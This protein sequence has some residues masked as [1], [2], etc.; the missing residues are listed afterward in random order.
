MNGI[1]TITHLTLHEAKGRKVM[2]AALILGIAFLVIFGIGFHFI[3]QDLQAPARGFV[4]RRMQQSVAI[5]F[6]GM[7]GLYA[8]NFLTVMMAVLMPVDTLSGEIRSGAIQTLV[9]KPISREQVV[10]GKWLGFWL[11]LAG[12]LLLMAGGVLLIVRWISG[13][14][15]N[16]AGAGIA[17]MLLESTVLLTLS[18][19]GGTR[20]STLANGVMV[21]GLYGFAFI[22]GWLEQIGTLLG[23]DTAQ[24]IGVI[25]SLVVPT[26]SLW[27]LAAYNM[28]SPLIRDLAITPFSVSSVP[29]SAMIVW[30]IAYIAVMLILALRQFRTRDL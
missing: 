24:N 30:A 13:Q 5:S 18:I 22:G 14:M 20:L 27:Q 21:F 17:L 15:T 7:A 28:Q 2:Q 26:E 8:V 1:L 4:P 6:I 16:N 19:L 12:Y 29:S 11:L 3:Y 10:L 23:N 25:T 9:S